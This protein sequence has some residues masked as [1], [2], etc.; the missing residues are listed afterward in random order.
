[1]ESDLI[2]KLPAELTISEVSD[3]KLQ[4][5]EYIDEHENIILD[6]SEVTRIDTA[7][8]QL[9]L[10]ALVYVSAQKKILYLGKAI[11]NYLPKRQTTW[12]EWI[13]FLVN[14]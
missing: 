2:F 6:G 3:Y 13:C 4:F 14:I 10:S 9:L 12:Y 1:M 5:I 8:I 7:G 11:I